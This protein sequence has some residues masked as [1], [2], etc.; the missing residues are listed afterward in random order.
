MGGARSL[1]IP[2]SH[3][4]E[5]FKAFHRRHDKIHMLRFKL[6][7]KN[8]EPGRPKIGGRFIALGTSLVVLKHLGTLSPF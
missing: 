8:K 7:L 4:L 2:P 5:P 6:S 1:E 3:G